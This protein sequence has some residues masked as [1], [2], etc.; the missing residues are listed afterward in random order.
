MVDIA[1]ETKKL[2]PDHRIF[3]MDRFGWNDDGKPGK[4]HRI[5]FEVKED[6]P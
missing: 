6:E 1:V 4:L 5:S 2:D 3:D